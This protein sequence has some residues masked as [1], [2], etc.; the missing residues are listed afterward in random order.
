M[1]TIQEKRAGGSLCSVDAQEIGQQLEAAALAMR[2]AMES[3]ANT[4]MEDSASSGSAAH[5]SASKA[6]EKE[7]KQVQFYLTPI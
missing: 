5:Q 6:G 4:G 2:M 7:N 3:D 1:P